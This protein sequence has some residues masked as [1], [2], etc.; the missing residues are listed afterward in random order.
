M[1]TTQ[2]TPTPVFKG[3]DN[4]GRPLA[5]GL[6]YSYEAGTTTQTPT[7]TDS[8]GLTPNT[9]PVVLNAR[10]EAPI[11]LNPTQGY[12]LNLTDSTGNQIP[13]WPVDNIIG[14]LNINQSLIPAADDAYDLGS[15]SS[16][17]RQLYLGAN[18]SPALDTVSGIIGYYPRTP[19]EIAAGVTPVNFAYPPWGPNQVFRYGAVGNGVTDDTVP[20]QT[21]V[22]YAASLVKS[23]GTYVYGTVAVELPSDY[24]FLISSISVPSGVGLVC[25]GMCYLLAKNT[26]GVMI[27]TPVIASG[28]TPIHNLLFEGLYLYG[29]GAT[30]SL[31]GL[32]INNCQNPNI[33]RCRF[34]NFAAQGLLLQSQFNGSTSGNAGL[35][36]CEGAYARDLR[37]FD[38]ALAA[39]TLAARTGQY[40]IQGTDHEFVDCEGVGSLTVGL[41]GANKYRVSWYLQ[42]VNGSRWLQCKGSVADQGWYEDSSSFDNYFVNIRADG[43]F[44]EGMDIA[45]NQNFFDNIECNGNG[46]QT[47]NTYDHF[48]FESTAGANYIAIGSFNSDEGAANSARYCITD[49]WPV[50]TTPN[51]LGPLIY[52]AGAASGGIH[53]AGG[54]ISVTLADG[55]PQSFPANSAT[56]SVLNGNESIKNWMTANNTATIITN[57]VNGFVGQMI[58]IEFGDSNTTI[59]NVPATIR[60]LTGSNITGANGAIFDFKLNPNG[61]WQQF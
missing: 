48:V 42:N 33:E 61:Y 4:N 5:F 60:T 46:T 34:S 56:P 8:T 32:R 37:A 36:T 18:H 7:Y 25:K 11:W 19:A 9:N 20:I 51:R 13:N 35:A 10:G 38:C 50:A 52:M 26:T 39:A 17:W 1:T 47:N 27:D 28:A 45:G 31:V 3:W 22:N 57:F 29:G 53:N 12:K 6:L 2:L 41:T 44:A 30:G 49:N 54:F 23:T 16:A 55:P 15:T 40:Q 24:S 14:P 21:L 43:N 58:R 59:Q